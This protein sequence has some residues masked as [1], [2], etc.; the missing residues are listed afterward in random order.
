MKENIII[1]LCDRPELI[2]FISVLMYCK[3]RCCK[4]TSCE[5]F[6]EKQAEIENTAGTCVCVWES[7]DEYLT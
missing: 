7:I 2:S 3:V 1:Y 4:V 5:I 6:A